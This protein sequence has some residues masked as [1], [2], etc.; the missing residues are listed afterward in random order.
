MKTSLSFQ[1]VV[2]YVESL[3]IEAQDLLFE[4]V[5]NRRI[6]KRRI[7]IA[8][9]AERTLAALQSGTA[10]RGSVTDLKADLLRLQ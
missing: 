10:N 1:A 4:L 5:I 7:K 2:E 8:A 6:E 3:P 9:N